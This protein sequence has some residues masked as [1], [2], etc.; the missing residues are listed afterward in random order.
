[1]GWL[2]SVGSIKFYVSFAEYSL[3]YRA[4]LQK[5]NMISSILLT[6]ATPYG[7]T[8]DAVVTKYR[9]ELPRI[10]GELLFELGLP[11]RHFHPT[12]YEPLSLNRD[13]FV[14]DDIWV[15]HS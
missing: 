10:V 3:F 14:T 13:S 9:R 12:A 1:M 6:E 2:R 4:L 8:Y 11:A 7:A 15:A 5:R